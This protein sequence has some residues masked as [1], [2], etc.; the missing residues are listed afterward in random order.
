MI[1]KDV[2]IIIPEIRFLE[3]KTFALSN[4]L[5]P[6][7]INNP[8]SIIISRLPINPSSS[9]IIEKMKSLYPCGRKKSF[10]ELLPNPTPKNFPL[11]ND[12]NDFI[13]WYPVP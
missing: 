8:K 13:I 11:A 12:T 3:I 9:A 4:I 7:N 2:R 1:C 5:N 6:L 10:W